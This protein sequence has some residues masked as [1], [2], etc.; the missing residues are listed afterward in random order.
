MADTRASFELRAGGYDGS[1]YEL[2]YDRAN[3]QL[4][5]TYYQAGAKRSYDAQL[6]AAKTLDYSH[7]YSA[8]DQINRCK[9]S[10]LALS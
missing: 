9:R 3:Y 5:G 6:C 10:F 4:K 7:D 2:T 1:T 8:T